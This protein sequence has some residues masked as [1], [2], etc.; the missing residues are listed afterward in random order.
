MRLLRRICGYLFLLLIGVIGFLFGCVVGMATPMGTEAI[1]VA[2]YVV[3]GLGVAFT[4]LLTAD[5][6]LKLKRGETD[7]L[8]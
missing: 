3:F 6:I 2:S 4:T 5:E 1:A 7:E 8:A